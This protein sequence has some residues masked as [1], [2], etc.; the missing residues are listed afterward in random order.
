MTPSTAEE[1]MAA[2]RAR[3]ADASAMLP[4]RSGSM[5]PAYLAGYAVEC[6]LKAFLQSRGF[7][8]PSTGRSGHDLRALWKASGF[9]L[10]D[11]ADKDGSKSFF[12]RRWSTDLRYE[13]RADAEETAETLVAGAQRLSRW[14][15]SQIRRKRRRSR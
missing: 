4:K 14:V 11:L 9:Q 10:R 15:N 8:R 13:A 5:G 7:P 2:S 12:V 1:W 3:G 6:A